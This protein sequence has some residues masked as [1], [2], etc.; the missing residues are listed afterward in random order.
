MLLETIHDTPKPKQHRMSTFTCK[1]LL[2]DFFK[3][4]FGR[5]LPIRR[6]EY[7]PLVVISLSVFFIGFCI[8]GYATPTPFTHTLVCEADAGSLVADCS[9]GEFCLV[10]GTVEV[11]A[12]E[13]RSPSIPASYQV[14]YLLTRGTTQRI[15]DSNTVPQFSVSRADRYSIH[16]LV[17]NDNPTS[18]DYLDVS[19]LLSGQNTISSLSNQLSGSGICA[20]LDQAGAFIRVRKCLIPFL[21]QARDDFMNTL[22]NTPVEGNILYND[23]LEVGVS[24]DLTLLGGPFNGSLALNPDGSVVYIPDPGFSGSDEFTYQVCDNSF[25]PGRCVQ[26]TG[27]IEVIDPLPLNNPP[28]ANLDAACTPEGIPVNIAV[29]ANDLDADGDLL[30]NP[31]SISSPFSGSVTY[32]AD[33]TITYTPNAGFSG[34]DSFKYQICDQGNPSLCDIGLVTIRVK[35]GSGNGLPPIP[36]D[37][38]IT[39]PVNTGRY[40]ETVI[41]NDREPD[42]D[43]INYSLFSGPQHGSLSLNTDGTYDYVPDQ[44]FVGPDFFVYTMSD[45]DGSAR[46]TVII[47]VHGS[48]SSFPVEW[49]SLG[50]S[51]EQANAI[52]RWETG[53]EINTDRFDIERSDDQGISFEKVGEQL[54]QGMSDQVSSYVYTDKNVLDLGLSTLMYRLK[55]WDLDGAFTYSRT[56]ELDLGNSPRITLSVSPNPAKEHVQITWNSTEEVHQVRVLN[57]LG[58]EVQTWN[59]S[60]PTHFG[61]FQWTLEGL[62]SGIYL[63]Q[64]Y[65]DHARADQKIVVE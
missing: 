59:F 39:M 12:S 43:P 58:K 49:L 47:T 42:G 44:D 63:I 65:S 41:E 53:L 57:L 13:N 52:V 60:N 61:S 2:I 15:V 11:S 56:F 33:G 31:T 19:A 1:L 23:H 45:I 3:S 36:M 26:A 27:Y 22:I 35:P 46:A 4:H 34:Y 24:Y 50:A 55:Q 6:K 21:I 10:A 48:G 28:V 30:Q 8:N 16:T 51:I 5:F 25:C 62:A 32:E 20:D 17:Y 18:P 38:A 40:G 37:D 7:S 64:S 29:L 14:V 54:A 9:N